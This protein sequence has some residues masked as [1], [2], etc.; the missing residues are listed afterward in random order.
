MERANL[1]RGKMGVPRFNRGAEAQ[2]GKPSPAPRRIAITVTWG[3]LLKIGIAALLAYTLVYLWRFELLLIL[4]VIIAVA[5]RP[6]LNWME[7]RGWPKWVGVFTT[8]FIM[9][10]VTAA[11]I[12]MIIPTVGNQSV[13]FV[14][15]LPEFKAALMERV[16]SIRPLH[17][18]VEPMVNGPTLSDPQPM[19]KKLMAVGSR[20]LEHTVEYFMVLIMALY[21]VMD[22]P[23]VYS[24][25]VAF[26]PPVH[27][28]KM[29]V[30]AD[31]VTSVVGHYVGGQLITSALA[32][33]F[34]FVVLLILGVP[35][36]AM[37][38]VLAG[39]FD[40]L[41]IIGFFLFTIPAVLM[42]LTVSPMAAA[43]VAVLYTVYNL[44][45]NYF[46]IPKV[47]GNR[48][49][50]STLTVLVTCVVAGLLAGVIG[51]IVA[52]PIVACYPVVERV[53]LRPYLERDTVAKHERL[54]AKEHS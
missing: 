6:M 52:L 29:S 46:I 24:W 44:I 39:V 26:L 40:V 23:R 8:G 38:A 37:L 42:A 30:A 10:G 5:F 51:V 11:V 49:R 45:E 15:R 31:D 3:A 27:R 28:K 17:N 50:L 22:G 34:A 2:E 41:P 53:W 13:D 20:A 19:L 12:G 47:Y 43:M 48:L 54:D 9:L 4:A 33:A 1:K 14:K 21:F 36:A 32:S 35:N 18:I 25:L 7:R 16:A